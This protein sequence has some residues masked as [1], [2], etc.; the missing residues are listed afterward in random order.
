MSDVSMNRS[1][2]SAAATPPR[3]SNTI[4]DSRAFATDIRQTLAAISDSNCGDS[5]S[6]KSTASSAE[7]S[8][9]NEVDR[10]HRKVRRRGQETKVQD[11]L[12]QRS[13]WR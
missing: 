1:N 10:I 2:S 12:E 9:I 13:V 5:T 8:M 7:L 6:W 11:L 4:A 3:R